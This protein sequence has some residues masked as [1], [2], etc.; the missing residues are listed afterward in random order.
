MTTYRTPLG[1][2]RGLGAAKHGVGDFIVQRLS[3]AALVLLLLWGVYAA[4]GV[5]RA[6]YDGAVGWLH[7]PINTTGVILVIAVAM[8]HMHIG[9]REIILDY[10]ER[11]I[12]KAGLLT[13][14]VFV[15]AGGAALG[16]IAVLR[17]AFGAV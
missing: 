10:I 17:V 14:N 12:T 4:L 8:L 1:R 3:G 16:A 11:P 9:M 7:A 5:A 15:C 6:G 2:V 13:L